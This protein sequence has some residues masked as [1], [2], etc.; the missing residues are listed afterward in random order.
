[1]E[2]SPINHVAMDA[3]SVFFVAPSAYLLSGLATWLDYLMPALEGRGWQTRLCLV[4][5]RKHHL[6]A[7]YLQAHPSPGALSAHCRTDTAVGRR[8]ALEKVLVQARPDVAV[9]VNIPD[10]FVAV[11]RLRQ[12][13][14]CSTRVVMS[15]HGIERY[16]YADMRLLGS[17]M[18]GV[19]CTNRLAC[20]LASSLGGVP[21][22]RISY[23][24]CGVESPT[25]R[26]EQVPRTD[27][28]LNIVYAG[29]LE[30]PQKRCLDLVE[31]LAGLRRRGVPYHL[32]IAGDG[33]DRDRLEAA[34]SEDVE[35]NRVAF[36]GFVPS[37]D[38]DSRLYANA[39]VMIIPSSWETGPIV[40]WEAM[41]RGICVVSSRYVGSG[42]EGALRSEENALMFD[43]GD[44]AGAAK[45][46]ERLWRDRV[47]RSTLRRSGA[48][49]VQSR[50][51]LKVSVDAWDSALRRALQRAP[52]PATT[53]PP[54]RGNGRLDRLL[55]VEFA[56][57]VR[58]ALRIAAPCA[59]NPGSEWP[60]SLSN[61]LS[62]SAFWDLAAKLDKGISFADA[63]A[64]A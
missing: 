25:A 60:H 63:G 12:I 58:R 49:L 47:L 57:S 30:S 56:E 37:G 23:A 38:L 43:V 44:A 8:R 42:L 39:D 54:A 34:L 59:S 52:R 10:L 17:V 18:D 24:A 11:N 46:L 1:M 40:A 51:S 4:S 15:V 2:A 13:G 50:Y 6:P 27:D 35:A 14:Q 19:A 26:A 33:P 32:A 29:R 45:A 36:H 16:L 3:P 5:S 21:E 31:V 53:L 20:A 55:G 7:P 62:D 28:R 22:G 64:A 48:E 9:S 41:A 61:A